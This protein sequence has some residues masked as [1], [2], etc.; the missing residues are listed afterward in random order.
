MIKK[1]NQWLKFHNTDA[2]ENGSTCIIQ[3]FN[4]KA[5]NISETSQEA[6]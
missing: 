1:E 6:R 2:G 5:N 4:L 3:E